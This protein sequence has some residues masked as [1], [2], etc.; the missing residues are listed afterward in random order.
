MSARYELEYGSK[1]FR[2][3]KLAKRRGLDM[4]EL[5]TV[6]DTL[7]EGKVLPPSI[8]TTRSRVTIKASVSAILILTGCLFT[9]KRI[10]CV[11]FRSTGQ[12]HTLTYFK[13]HQ[14]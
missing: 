13:I 4:R 9:A 14:Y 5:K 12:E 7:Q 10:P 3:L 1:F 6:T 8:A 11:S 2:D